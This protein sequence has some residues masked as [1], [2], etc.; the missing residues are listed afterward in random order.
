MSLQKLEREFVLNGGMDVKQAADLQDEATLRQVTNLRWDA[1]GEL[2]KRPTYASQANLSAPSGADYTDATPEAI[3]ARGPEVCA[4]T[5][6]CGMYVVDPTDPTSALAPQTEQQLGA[7]ESMLKYSPR[8]CKVSRRFIE[9][10]QYTAPNTYIKQV[11]SAVY[12][13]HLVIAWV[14]QSTGASYFRMKAVHKDT[15]VVLA[16]A[17]QGVLGGGA[18]GAISSLAA[19]PYLVE[20]SEGVMVTV[21]HGTVAPFTIVPVLYNATARTFTAGSNLTTNAKY[22]THATANEYSGEKFYLA[23]CDNTSGFMTAQ[24]RSVSTV[25][26]THTG[27]A[28]NPQFFAF[29]V[30][31]EA[32]LIASATPATAVYAEVFGTPAN[33]ITVHAA[34]G[35]SFLGV[36]CSL[37]NTGT[38]GAVVYA[39]RLGS[40]SVPRELGVR[41]CTVTFPSTTPIAGLKSVIPS[42]WLAGA[43]LSY[44]SRSYVPLILNPFNNG[45]Y[46]ATSARTSVLLCRYYENTTDGVA[47]MEPCARFGHERFFSTDSGTTGGHQTISLSGSK[48]HMVFAAD[49]SEDYATFGVVGPQAIFQATIEFPVSGEALPLPSVQRGNKLLIASGVTLEWDGDLLM[50]AQPLDRPKLELVAYTVIG[51]GDS[52]AKSVNTMTITDSAAKFPPDAAGRSISISSATSPGNNGTFTIT[53]RISDTSVSWTNAAGVAEVFPGDW[54]I[55]AGVPAGTYSVKAEAQAVDAAGELHRSGPSDAATV[56]TTAQCELWAYVSKPLHTAFD[57]TTARG[58]QANVYIT[59]KDG[60]THYLACS[61][62]TANDAEP[63]N[64]ASATLSTA[65]HW[66]FKAVGGQVGGSTSDPPLPYDSGEVAPTPPPAFNGLVS[67]GD[68]TWGID[69]ED[70]TRL[71]AA[72]PK[73][74]GFATEWST[75]RTLVVG[76]DCVAITDSQ[77][78]PTML[79]RTGVWQVFGN[80]PDANGNGENFA[81]A[82]KLAFEVSCID[83]NVCRTSAG[84][85]FRGPRGFYMLGNGLEPL[86]LPIDP[87]TRAPSLTGYTYT[88]M[89]FDE[90]ANELRLVD[91]FTGKY[92]VY[93]L[94]EQKWSEWTQSAAGQDVR[95]LVVCQGR[96][97]YLHRGVSSTSIRREYGLDEVDDVSRSTDSWSIATPKLRADN[98]MGRGRIE[99]LHL[100]IK[101]RAGGGEDDTVAQVDALTVTLELFGGLLENSQTFTWTGAQLAALGSG[102]E[103]VLNLPIKPRNNRC[104]AMRV[105]VT[106]A[107]NDDAA[108]SGSS[109]ISL[110]VVMGVDGKAMRAAKGAAYRNPG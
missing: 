77:G 22:A 107:C 94:L 70:P 96:V 44:E 21:A 55:D 99:R 66:V 46:S 29:A 52:L 51:T 54:V 91:D 14:D 87:S 36:A 3:F 88:R 56:T 58:M 40:T 104:S 82:Q 53:A 62:V 86:S 93:N 100:A 43:A 89:A 98:I 76:D 37:E 75:D 10:T 78:T 6:D 30:H 28:A 32:V 41:T 1:Q 73:V 79:G 23:F 103:Q 18:A 25:T 67:I 64:Y 60:S 16:T 72:K 110:R 47:R 27:A 7:T 71:W 24:Y 63:K 5:A 81:P 31:S 92:W 39:N 84:V 57:A 11:V 69:A 19:I 102:N 95:D 80:G 35:E 49:G 26:T 109:P 85:V 12:G 97:W 108:Y 17:R 59:E 83:R 48:M 9:R 4:L 45:V 61:H 68:L 8:A 38:R 33:R 101:V 15:G 90:V 34:S 74:A 2:R 20:G 105:T 42:T 106:E 50:E 13:D 65:Y